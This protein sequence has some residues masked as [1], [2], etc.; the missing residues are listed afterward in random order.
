MAVGTFGGTV[1]VIDPGADEEGK[2]RIIVFPD[3]ES[4]QDWPNAPYLR[5]GVR[6]IGWVLLDSVPLGWELWRQFNGF[7]P[8]IKNPPVVGKKAPPSE[9]KKE[10]K[11]EVGGK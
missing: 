5:Q 7:P 6:V 11:D 9:S 2:V 8:S 10:S 3:E 4:S 1:G